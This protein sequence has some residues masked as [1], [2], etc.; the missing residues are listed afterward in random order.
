ME[1]GSEQFLETL[2]ETP[3]PSGF[4]E[5]NLLNWRE[6]VEGQV[7]ELETDAYGNTTATLNPGCETSVVL[8]GHVDEIGFM[9]NHITDDGY[10]YLKKIGGVDLG[11]AQGQR[12][13][14]HGDGDVPGVIGR[15]PVHLQETEDEKQPEIDDIYVDVGA[16][17]ADDVRD[18]G[19]EVGDT[20][21][22]DVGLQQLGNDVVAGRG[23]DNRIG[24]WVVAE[25][26]RQIDGDELD[27]TV[28][29]VA[30]VQEELG[31]RGAKMSSYSI[32]PDAALVVDVTFSTDVPKVSPEKHGVVELG[33][34]PSLKHGK[35]NHPALVEGL[36]ETADELEVDLQHEAILSHGATDA[37]AFFVSRGG[38]PSVFVG[39][40]NR[41][42]HTPAELVSTSDLEDVRDLFTGYVENLD[43]DVEYSKI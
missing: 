7:D 36:E 41:N 2:I 18:M 4:E 12:V 28:H 21:T 29:G 40:P 19:I 35:E 22:Y 14:V 34:G 20:A 32:D 38:I 37:D 31:L 26:L 15:T 9:V 25:A 13:M 10:I 30:T 5:S 27:V 1:E 42:M 43:S 33:E 39:V 24:V 8:T 3:S 16:E 11:V 17:D 23:L 6:R